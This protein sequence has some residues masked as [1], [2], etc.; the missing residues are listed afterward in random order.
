MQP[1]MFQVR[2]TQHRKFSGE[3]FS[4]KAVITAITKTSTALFKLCV[5][6]PP[7]APANGVKCKSVECKHNPIYLAGRYCKYSRELC[8]TPWIIDG[9]KTMET[10]VQ[11]IIFEQLTNTFG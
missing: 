4:R 9:V 1:D 6:V 3:L 8:Q 5:K 10:S 11:E 7:E 2:K